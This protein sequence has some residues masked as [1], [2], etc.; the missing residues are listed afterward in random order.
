VERVAEVALASGRVTAWGYHYKRDRKWQEAD[1][2]RPKDWGKARHPVLVA[3]GP[4][5]AVLSTA[6]AS[7]EQRE[8]RSIWAVLDRA[9]SRADGLTLK[10]H[11]VLHGGQPIDLIHDMTL[12]ATLKGGKLRVRSVM[13]G[14]RF[15]E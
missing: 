6:S 12:T 5:G 11:C 2:P 3:Q 1:G 14:K 15:D 10:Y 9:A 13:V 4:D 8:E 7:C